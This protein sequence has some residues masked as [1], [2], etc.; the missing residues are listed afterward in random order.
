MHKLL[1]HL[2]LPLTLVAGSVAAA[3]VL[4]EGPEDAHARAPESQPPLV[5]VD[6]LRV[7]EHRTRVEA[8]GVAEATRAL[9]LVPEVG[10]K[11]VFVAEQLDEGGRVREGEVLVRIEAR[12]YTIAL[13][14]AK[15]ELA[16]AEAELELERGRGRSAKREWERYGG[17]DQ[18]KSGRLASRGP[19][20]AS[21]E[22]MVELR[23]AAVE[24]AKLDLRR[25]TIRAPFDALVTSEQVEAGQVVSQGSQLASLVAAD[26]LWVRAPL[27]IEALDA[28]DLAAEREDGEGSPI[29]MQ[30]PTGRG[31]SVSVTGEALRL[32][33]NIDTD[34]RKVELIIRVV[35]EPETSAALL[36]GAF[37]TLAFES[38]RPTRALQFPR[39]ALV[40]GRRVW[41]V[42]EDERLRRL[43]LDIAWTDAD[44]IFVRPES[45][46]P[47]WAE[48]AEQRGLRVVRRP[49]PA[50]LEGMRVRIETNADT[51]TDEP[52][53]DHD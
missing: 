23:K 36:P 29:H 48:A 43:D 49:S 20:L 45:L 37:V 33:A 27:R 44:S 11:V 46:G 18:D 52:E 14:Q 40:D 25:A 7:A 39:D 16:Q 9:T 32:G 26:E 21:A 13:N 50:A 31:G 22:A 51:D 12:A 24:R 15:A 38:P 17:G 6:T 5:S 35:R 41:L 30:L 28:L 34:T 42:D 47:E 10:G 53:A 2:V 3:V 19:Q 8:N 1:T 4:I